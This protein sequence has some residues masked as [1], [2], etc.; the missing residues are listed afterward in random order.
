MPG[1]TEERRSPSLRDSCARLFVDGTAGRSSYPERLFVF[2]GAAQQLMGC[3]AREV[4]LDGPA[5][6][7]KS[8]ACIAKVH[9]TCLATPNVRCLVVRKARVSLT[10]T[11]LVTF[12][13]DVLG[14][15]NPLYLN[16]PSR[17]GRQSY[18]YPNGSEIVVG[19]LDKASKILSADYDLI[20]VQQAEE[21]TEDDWELIGTR[22]RHGRLGYHQLLADCNPSVPSHWLKRRSE[23]GQTLML[24]SRHE[25][26]PKLHNGET[27]T[28]AG[29]EY[30]HH[31]LEALTGVRRERYLKGLWVAA[32]GMV[33]GDVWDARRHL[34]DRFDV[35]DSWRRFIAVD[36]GYT[37]PFV[38]QW[39]ALDD[40]DRMYLYREIYMTRRTVRVHAQQI[41][42]LSVGESIETA[43]CDHDAEDRATLEESGIWTDPAEKAVG[44]GIQHVAERLKVAGDCRPRLF[45]MR[46][47]VVEVDETLR[48]ATLPWCTEQEVE[49]YVWD[50]TPDGR[51]NKETPQKLHDHGCDALRYAVM[52][53]DTGG[54]RMMVEVV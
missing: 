13:Q 37:N 20:Y 39:W 8:L 36:F 48:E 25:D 33:Y 38:A 47:S 26:N 15:G 2:R 52:H 6:T 41:N 29:D 4:V 28:A 9:T 49:G 27:W 34:I 22:L 50:R 16:G 14:A 46:D 44:V 51:P 43:V 10:T 11:G 21:I 24:H 17:A 12:E 23:V 40:D 32:E 19:G 31:R 45:I 5:G 54:G 30:V 53:A 1:I 42:A 7:G 35:P 18:R 3:T